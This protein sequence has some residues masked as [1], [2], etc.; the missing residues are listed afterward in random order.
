M[1]L[2]LDDDDGAPVDLV[3]RGRAL[4]EALGDWL[5][6]G[7]PARDLLSTLRPQDVAAL[8][9]TLADPEHLRRLVDAAVFGGDHHAE[10]ALAAADDRARSP[11]VS[12]IVVNGHMAA[13]ADRCPWVYADNPTPPP[14]NADW[15]FA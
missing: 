15:L 2:P 12:R 11:L 6:E 8:T 14:T 13:A 10:A 1:T 5:A 9:A 7:S 3:A 4:A